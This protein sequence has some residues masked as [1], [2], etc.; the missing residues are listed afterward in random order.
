MEFPYDQ[1]SK[2]SILAYAKELLGNSLRKLHPDSVAYSSGKGSMGQSV[3][4][5][6]FLYHPNDKPEPDFPE[7]GVELK[8]TPI[9]QNADGS[10][11]SKERLV[12]NIIDYVKEAQSTFY[13]SS[14]WQKNQFLLLMF[15]L[16]EKGIDVVDL[17][18]KIV[19]F[20]NFPDVDLKII[21]D[22]WEK[23]H[24]KMAHGLAHEISEG[25]TLYLGACTKGSKSGVEM[26]EQF[27][28]GAEKA[29]Q[30]AYSIKQKYINTIILDSLLHPEMCSGVY[31]SVA[32]RKKI[33]KTISKASNAVKSLGEY[34][35]GETFEDLIERRFA[36]YYG[37]TVYEIEKMTGKEVT[38]SPKS[39]SNAVIHVILGVT[40]PKIKEFEK[41]NL[42]QKS[43]R[44][45]PN[46]RLV[47]SMVFEQI[48]YREIVEEEEWEDSVLYNLLTRRFLFV[49]FKKDSSGDNKKATLEKVFFWTMPR[50]DLE[51]A[52]RF[53]EDTKNKIAADDFEHFW[54]LSDHN[55]CHVRPKAKN[56]QDKMEAPSGRMITKKGYWLNAEYIQSVIN[57]V[58]SK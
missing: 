58:I 15:Y 21:K 46:G 38:S 9:K 22:D 6:H 50:K 37:K 31:M 43:I 41:A 44:L 19:R 42:Q 29:Q 8:C 56:N 51:I 18:F 12:L 57:G 48:K 40:T 14:F 32:Q 23:L 3:E 20:W 35:Q 2:D 1:T 45:E 25:D 7:A 39:I 11:V 26:R 10:M 47:E 33:E 4:M 49:V 36:R 16:H 27:V 17:I 54:K 52:S 53:W 5:Y 34:E 28:Q 13:T 24:W 55:I 30:R